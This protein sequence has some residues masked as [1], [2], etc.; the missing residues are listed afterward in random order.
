MCDAPYLAGMVNHAMKNETVKIAV[1][2]YLADMVNHTVKNEMV[3]ITDALLFG[4]WKSMN[5]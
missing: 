1:V 3:K 4:M 5:I 2:L